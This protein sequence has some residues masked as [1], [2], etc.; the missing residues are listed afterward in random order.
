MGAGFA[1][2]TFWCCDPQ[3]AR[4][5]PRTQSGRPR[6]VEPRKPGFLGILG[7]AVPKMR[8]RRPN[9]AQS[10]KNKKKGV[11]NPKKRGRRPNYKIKK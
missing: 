10:P 6:D 8:G 3:S 5:V 7:V 2:P 11:A 4:A 1:T 9:F